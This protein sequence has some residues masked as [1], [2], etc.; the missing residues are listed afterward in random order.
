M[1]TKLFLAAALAFMILGCVPS[2]HKLYTPDV[3]VFDEAL[4]GTWVGGDDIWEFQ[5]VVR[6]KSEDSK[7]FY[8]LRITDEKDRSAKFE[9]HLVDLDDKL[10]LDIYPTDEPKDANAWYKIHVLP[11]HTFVCLEIKDDLLN[12]QVM[13]PETM[14]RLVEDDP[15]MIKHEIIKDDRLVLTASTADLQRFL[16]DCADHDDF[17]GDPEQ[18]ER[19]VPTDP[20]EVEDKAKL[21]KPKD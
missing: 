15:D 21:D 20:N 5:K 9:A 6:P 7:L 11:V 10:F 1:K 8:S 3:E 19:F 12:M 4:L 14:N 2:L 16:K 18:F 13:N 17:Y